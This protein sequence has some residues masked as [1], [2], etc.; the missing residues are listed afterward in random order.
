MICSFTVYN[1]VLPFFLPH[2][3]KV[4]QVSLLCNSR[5]FFSAPKNNL[6]PINK[7]VG[8][9][10][11]HSHAPAL[12]SPSSLCEKEMAFLYPQG[13]TGWGRCRRQL[14]AN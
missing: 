1:S 13:R 11:R 7:L 8:R 3:Y 5:T 2:I 6:T 12:A 9:R 4:E 10:T 14:A